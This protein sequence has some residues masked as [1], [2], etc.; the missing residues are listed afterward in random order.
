MNNFEQGAYN[1][2]EHNHITWPTERLEARIADIQNRM[3]IITYSGERLAQ[4]QR[5]L[6]LI[7][8]ELASRYR[9]K[10]LGEIALAWKERENGNVEV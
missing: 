1:V 3:G 6:D 2:E 5:E 7:A 9:E 8:F 4:N 10:K